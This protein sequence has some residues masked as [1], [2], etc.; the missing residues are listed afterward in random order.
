MKKDIDIAEELEDQGF[1]F[2]WGDREHVEI[3]RHCFEKIRGYLDWVHKAQIMIASKN[4]LVSGSEDEGQ[5][6]DLSE[7]QDLINR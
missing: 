6:F 5:S 4:S 1:E 3:V 2:L 7:L